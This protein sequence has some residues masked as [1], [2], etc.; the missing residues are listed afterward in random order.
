MICCCVTAVVVQILK[1]Y[2]SQGSVV[3]RIRC[4]GIFNDYFITGFPQ[5][6]S[7]KEL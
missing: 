5:S 3:M 2:I 1:I 6:V 4:G 7:V